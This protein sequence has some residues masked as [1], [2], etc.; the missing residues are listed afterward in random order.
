M[1]QTR[2]KTNNFFSE[3]LENK[4]FRYDLTE[5]TY[6]R[7]TD[8]YRSKDCRFMVVVVHNPIG[9]ASPNLIIIDSCLGELPYD[10][11]TPTLGNTSFQGI[12]KN[13]DELNFLFNLFGF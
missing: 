12:V 6:S 7:K 9:K 5:E 11:T 3:I 4:G 2:N 13:A 1:A 8:Y 10:S